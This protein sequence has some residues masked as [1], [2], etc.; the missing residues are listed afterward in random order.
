MLVRDFHE[1][2]FS[3]HAK[4]MCF[5]DEQIAAILTFC[6]G[7]LGHWRAVAQHAVNPFDHDQGIRRTIAEATQSLREVVGVI[8]SKTNDFGA[9]HLTAV[10]DAC[11][12]VTVDHDDIVAICQRGQDAEIREIPGRKHDGTAPAEKLR[13]ILFEPDVTRECPVRHA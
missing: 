13:D 7:D 3:E 12:A 9:A 4:R 11:V 6:R 2:A 1:A 8:V 5:V 10:V